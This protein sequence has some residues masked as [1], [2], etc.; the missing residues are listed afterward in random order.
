MASNLSQEQ[1]LEN[2]FSGLFPKQ[3]TGHIYFSW[4]L[5]EGLNN[6]TELEQ[7]KNKEKQLTKATFPGWTH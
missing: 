5:I 4:S 1:T 3:L 6:F 2:I 7:K